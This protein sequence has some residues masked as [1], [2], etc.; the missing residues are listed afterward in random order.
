MLSFSF[1]SKPGLV[2]WTPL[3]TDWSR[4]AKIHPFSYEQIKN[5]K[6]AKTRCTTDT[7]IPCLLWGSK[8]GRVCL[9][10][11]GMYSCVN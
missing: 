4:G 5:I 3:R 6:Q 11:N 1:S 10:N 9:L 7:K 2:A 8:G